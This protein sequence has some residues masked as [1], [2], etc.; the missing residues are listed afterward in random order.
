MA[1]FK[2]TALAG[3]VMRME[4]EG[5]DRCRFRF[6]LHAGEFDVFFFADANPYVLSF[7]AIGRNFYFEVNVNPRTLDT[8][9]V[10]DRGDYYSLC[11]ILGL[12]PNPENKFTPSAFLQHLNN[13]IEGVEFHPVTPRDLA[14]YRRDVEESAKI[15][16][17]G[18]LDNT[19]TGNHVTPEN[20][21]KTRRWLGEKAYLRCK[22]RNISSRWTDD[23]SKAKTFSL[24]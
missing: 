8:P 3:L 23:P 15:W 19:T 9:A 16:F 5:V 6:R 14:T 21:N 18:W 12:R 7:G 11:E 4:Q 13:A 22:E 20:L 24:P 10:F 2:M 17:C 1:Y